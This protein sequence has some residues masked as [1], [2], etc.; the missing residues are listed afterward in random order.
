[1]NLR[2]RHKH[3]AHSHSQAPN[4]AEPASWGLLPLEGVFAPL[5]FTL[6]GR[7]G[8]AVATAG[9]RWGLQ[10]IVGGVWVVPSLCGL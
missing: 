3:S 5:V 2:G 4:Q 6:G 7:R 9:R 8:V 10:E 1:M